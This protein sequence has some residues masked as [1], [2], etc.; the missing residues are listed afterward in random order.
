LL[1][2]TRTSLPCGRL[3]AA[4]ICAACNWLAATSRARCASSSLAGL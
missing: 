4:W 2:A 3:L 1:R